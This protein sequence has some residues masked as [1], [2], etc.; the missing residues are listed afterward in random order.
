MKKYRLDPDERHPMS[1]FSV[2][3]KG[4]DSKG[5]QNSATVSTGLG[6]LHRII[7]LRPI[8]SLGVNK[9]DKG[10]WVSSEEN[11]SQEG[12]CWVW[13]G[14]MVRDKA[15]VL[16]DAQIRDCAVISDEAVVENKAVVAGAAQ[17]R[18]TARICG[19]ACVGSATNRHAGL[20]KP[21]V[22][23]RAERDKIIEKAEMEMVFDS[24]VVLEAAEVGESAEVRGDVVVKGTAVL[25]GKARVEGNT[26][27]VIIGGNA[28]LGGTVRAIGEAFIT[29]GTHEAG[30]IRT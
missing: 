6:R 29:T 21:E 25:Y 4:R 5:N 28:R 1:E 8:P 20:L 7:A 10:G 3:Q 9:D 17:I 16:D 23:R 2:A 27:L 12:D 18:D 19:Y 13:P 26:T 14:A 15:T 22:Y 24:P 30:I 11:L